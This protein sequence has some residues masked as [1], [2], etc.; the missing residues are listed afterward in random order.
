MKGENNCISTWLPKRRVTAAS[1]FT[2]ERYTKLSLSFNAVFNVF[3]M[4]G[5]IG[6]S[7]SKSKY[8]SQKEKKRI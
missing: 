7:I 5:K 2:A 3:K 6:C 4:V 1:A 8:I